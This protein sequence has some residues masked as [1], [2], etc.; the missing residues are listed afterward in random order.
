VGWPTA[1]RLEELRTAWFDAPDL[2]SQKRICDDLQLQ[3]W[4][5]VPYIPLGLIRRATAYRADLRDM[6]EGGVLFTG[7]HRA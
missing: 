4:Q 1:P 3:V 5:D 6:P 2:A 7:A